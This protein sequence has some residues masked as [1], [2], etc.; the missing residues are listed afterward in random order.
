MRADRASDLFLVGAGLVM[1]WVLI[2]GPLP[3]TV[4]LALLLLGAIVGLPHGALD[5]ELLLGLD[6]PVRRLLG[7]SLYAGLALLV[8]IGWWWQPGAA[9]GLFLLVGGIHFGLSDR[10]LESGWPRWLEVLARG[11][12]PIFGSAWLHGGDVSRIFAQLVPSTDAERLTA[13]L[14][15]AAPVWLVATG[16]VVVWSLSQAVILWRPPGGNGVGRQSALAARLALE[17]VALLLLFLVLSPLPAFAL[18]FA[19]LHSPRALSELPIRGIADRVGVRLRRALWPTLLSLGLALLVLV[20]L[21]TRLS[22]DTALLRVVFIGLAALTLPHVVLPLVL[23]QVGVKSSQEGRKPAGIA[24][25]RALSPDA[26]PGEQMHMSKLLVVDD[27]PTERNYLADIL[28][29]AGHR[30]VTAGSGREAIEHSLSDK[31]DLIFMDVVMEEM[32]GYNATREILEN[33][34]TRDIPVVMVTS[35]NQKADRVWAQM[36]GAKGYIVKPYTEEQV[37]EQL[38]ELL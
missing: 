18:Y 12:A 22:W 8:V 23:A 3:A 35:K 33:E 2:V 38:R 13:L 21:L 11:G 29:R 10:L 31:P 26:Q 9:L 5:A 30:V 17:L 20:G 37:L 15:S 19:L 24:Y 28:G 14:V 1:A 6:S 32:D 7:L 16:V 4:S 36:Q 34:Q 27:S 25:T